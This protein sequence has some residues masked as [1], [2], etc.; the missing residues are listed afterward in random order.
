VLSHFHALSCFVL[1]LGL[2][3]DHEQIAEQI[4][5]SAAQDQDTSLVAQSSDRLSGKGDDADADTQTLSFLNLSQSIDDATASNVEEN[6]TL[7]SN[8]SNNG[9]DE[10]HSD[11]E[12]PST[13]SQLSNQL[14]T[15]EDPAIDKRFQIHRPLRLVQHI[16]F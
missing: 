9:E 4:K 10:D 1:G 8:S 7:D 11:D 3:E 6:K 12:G 15:A 5:E 2:S 14:L 13:E 16:D